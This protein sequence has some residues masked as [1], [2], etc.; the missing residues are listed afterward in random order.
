MNAQC[1]HCTLQSPL[2]HHPHP[3]NSPSLQLPDKSKSRQIEKLESWQVGK[4]CHLPLHHQP[5]PAAP[6]FSLTPPVSKHHPPLPPHL[7]T[8][9]LPYPRVDHHPA[10]GECHRLARP[11]RPTPCSTAPS[12]CSPS[13]PGVRENPAS[14]PTPCNRPATLLPP[15]CS[16]NLVSRLNPPH[17]LIH[18]PRRARRSFLLPCPAGKPP[19]PSS[20]GTLA[21]T[22]N[23]AKPPAASSVS[24]P[25]T[26]QRHTNHTTAALALPP[27]KPR[28][29]RAPLTLQ[30]SDFPTN[31]QAGKLASWHTPPPTSRAAPA[32][33]VH[34]SSH[35]RCAL[36]ALS[37]QFI[38][39]P[40]F[41]RPAP[42]P[43]HPSARLCRRSSY[44]GVNQKPA[45]AALHSTRR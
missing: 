24:W 22:R 42:L 38:P 20:G 29:R 15:W 43:T 32:R 11:R 7:F 9:L 35:P 1:N 28:N 37:F 36:A 44:P 10:A 21:S 25:A 19:P 40:R 13:Y 39:P 18:H 27:G 41:R 4:H 26:T 5:V 17:P 34:T 2:P 12:L 6:L 30:L 8:P 14:A 31:R 16:P 3:A 45:L 23:A 33:I